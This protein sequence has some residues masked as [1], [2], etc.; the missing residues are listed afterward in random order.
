MSSRFSAMG[1]EVCL[2]G[3]SAAV[4][5]AV[6]DLFARRDRMFSR[7]HRDSELCRVNRSAGRPTPVSREFAATVRVALRVAGATD[8]L[9]VPTLGE[10]LEAAGYDRDFG[11]L[12]GDR[13]PV[14]AVEPPPSWR[15]IRLHGRVLRLPEGCQLDLNGVV[16]AMTVDAAVVMLDGPGWVSAGGDLATRGGI[17]LDL[18]G[19]G[20]VHLATGGI[21]TSGQTARRWRRGGGWQHHLIDPATARPARS[22]WELVTAV[23][24]TCVDADAAA[25]AAFLADGVGPGWLDRQGIPGRFVSLSGAVEQNRSWQAQMGSAAACT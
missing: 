13:G 22:R 5:E 25:K 14:R 12:G 24:V 20:A 17:D 21:A 9:V 15:A 18:P 11:D 19:G 3:A 7:F 23:G 2:E 16:K 4:F 8:G 6:R 1:C 10:A